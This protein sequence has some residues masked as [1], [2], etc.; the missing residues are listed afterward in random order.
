MKSQI[1]RI[2]CFLIDPKSVIFGVAIFNFV[3]VWLRSP[4]WHFH[5][6]IFMATLLIASSLLLLLNK[7]WSNLLAAIL[8]GYLP[9]EI[10]WEFWIF[11]HN[12]EVPIF[13]YRHFSFFFNNSEIDGK[14]VL[15]IGLTLMILVQAV[16]GVMRSIPKHITSNEA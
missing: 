14:V 3:W 5:R 7:A 9:I 8:S 4:E 15:F 10:L 2:I 11:A 1:T 6:N 16:F 12:A 13:S